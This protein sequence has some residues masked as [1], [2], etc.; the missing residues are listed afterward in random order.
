MDEDYYTNNL[1]FLYDNGENSIYKIDPLLFKYQNGNTAF[2]IDVSPKSFFTLIASTKISNEKNNPLINPNNNI[3]TSVDFSEIADSNDIRLDLTTGSVVT[4]DIINTIASSITIIEPKTYSDYDTYMRNI[5][6]PICESRTLITIDTLRS[7]ISILYPNSVM[8]SKSSPNMQ[9]IPSQNLISAITVLISMSV[10]KKKLLFDIVSDACT[11][12]LYSIIDSPNF[13]SSNLKMF[14]NFSDILPISN[15][16]IELRNN[17]IHNIIIPSSIIEDQSDN[18]LLY[19]KKLIADIYIKTSYPLIQYDFLNGIM[20]NYIELGDYMNVRFALL[21]KIYFTYNFINYIKTNLSTGI[22]HDVINSDAVLTAFLKNLNM[23]DINA[24]FDQQSE[25]LKQLQNISSDVVVQSVDI[26]DLSS[27]ITLNQQV[28]R[29]II[30]NNEISKKVYNRQKAIFWIIFS[31]LLLLILS[32]CLLIFIKKN[33]YVLY[34]VS[35][36]LMTIV[37][38]K[39]VQLIKY[40]FK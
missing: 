29:N 27:Q 40:F 10:K 7:S 26:D 13:Q 3:E 34:I 6:L 14:T 17:L 20:N 18:I 32:S 38:M 19:I 12:S 28:F 30:T 39:L 24:Q 5:I 33:E 25:V 11:K 22:I 36:L 21:A 4:S 15:L 31:L 8:D 16:Y 35:L 23:I 2:N 1:K 9:V 37:I